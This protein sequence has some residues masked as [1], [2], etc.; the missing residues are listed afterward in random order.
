MSWRDGT[1]SHLSSRF[2]FARVKVAQAG[3]EPA[4]PEA[5]WLVVEWPEGEAQPTKF[6]LES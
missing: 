5:E 6:F 3:F 2:A 4:E 1:N